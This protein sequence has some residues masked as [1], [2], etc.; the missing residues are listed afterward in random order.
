MKS[1]ALN[2]REKQMRGI[3]LIGL[4]VNV[5]LTTIKLLGGYLLRSASLVAD[6]IHTISDLVTDVMVLFGVRI[7][8]R[9]A[10]E[11]HPYGHKKFESVF[12]FLV[13]MVLLLVSV[14][15]VVTSVRAIIL[16]KT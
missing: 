16:Q 14:Q 12:S 1:E 11:T 3:T 8:N 6:G 7:A 13:G 15:L 2:Q 4:V 10:D 5:F 9:P